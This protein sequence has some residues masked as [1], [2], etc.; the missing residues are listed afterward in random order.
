MRFTAVALSNHAFTF[1]G[2]AFICA[3]K[4]PYIAAFSEA[5]LVVVRWRLSSTMEKPSSTS[6]DTL[7]ASI[8]IKTTYIRFI[9]F[10]RGDTGLFF[11]A[12]PYY[13]SAL[14]PFAAVARMF[15][16]IASIMRA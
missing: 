14:F 1:W 2:F 7:S 11:I 6:V 8:A 10:W 13:P 16:V 3:S 9:I 12:M 15:T 5:E 4:S